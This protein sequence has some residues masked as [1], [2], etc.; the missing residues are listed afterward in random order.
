MQNR[1]HKTD[2]SAP[3]RRADLAVL[4]FDIGHAA[5]SGEARLGP[6]VAQYVRSGRLPNTQM[7]DESIHTS[8]DCRRESGK[9]AYDIVPSSEPLI[10]TFLP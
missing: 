3:Y 5:R 2:I 8:L 10:W 1:P 7:V 6:L 4:S 9:D